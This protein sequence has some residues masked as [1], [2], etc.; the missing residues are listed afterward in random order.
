[1]NKINYEGH[2][3]DS[4]KKVKHH[5]NAW[6]NQRNSVAALRLTKITQIFVE[7]ESRSNIASFRNDSALVANI[8]HEINQN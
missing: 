8:S 6:K 2:N 7:E 1:M 5:L 3:I 4:R